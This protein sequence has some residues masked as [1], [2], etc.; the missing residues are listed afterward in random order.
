MSTTLGSK[1]AELP[2]TDLPHAVE[3]EMTPLV[4]WIGRIVSGM[5]ILSIAA[6][7]WQ[8]FSHHGVL[9]GVIHGLKASEV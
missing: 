7:I 2:K 6:G 9:S 4:R 5:L 8:G 1:P 3:G